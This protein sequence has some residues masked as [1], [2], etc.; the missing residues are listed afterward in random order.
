M[1]TGRAAKH[2]IASIYV[3][4]NFRIKFSRTQTRNSPQQRYAPVDFG[5]E[6][7][8]AD[9]LLTISK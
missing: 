2:T 7:H 6:R 1:R 8:F 4:I 5:L 9:G 3:S